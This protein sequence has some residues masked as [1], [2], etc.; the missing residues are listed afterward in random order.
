MSTITDTSIDRIRNDLRNYARDMPN[1]IA[2]LMTQAEATLRF[3]QLSRRRDAMAAGTA[4]PGSL[5]APVA[6]SVTYNG[7]HSGNVFGDRAKAYETMRRLDE[8]HGDAG[9]TVIPLVEQ[10]EG[11]EK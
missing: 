3:F 10:L 8:E 1:H 7:Q 9:R 4:A 6:W 11:A 2:L 5:Q